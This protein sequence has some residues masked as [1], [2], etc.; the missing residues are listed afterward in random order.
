VPVS[1]S[2]EGVGRPLDASR[3]SDLRRA[4]A[5]AAGT[6]LPQAEANDGGEH[7]APPQAQ[8]SVVLLGR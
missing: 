1:G 2:T 3:R 8:N 6:Q 7:D 5:E 4:V